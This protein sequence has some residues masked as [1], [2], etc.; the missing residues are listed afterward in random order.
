MDVLFCG[1]LEML[2]LKGKS[3]IPKEE[4]KARKKK[5]AQDL[6]MLQKYLK[7][8]KIPVIILFEGLEAAGKGSVI[9]FMA[10]SM[11]PRGFKVFP[12]L[13]PDEKEKSKPFLYRFWI[14]TPAKGFIHIFDRSWYMHVLE[15]RV[16]K[17]TG[18]K[19]CHI[20]FDEI[21]QFERTL[22]DNGT[23]VIKFWLH[24]SEKEQKKRLKKMEKS[25]EHRWRVGKKEWRQHKNY[26]K[27]IY[28][29][30]D[31]FAATNTSWSPWHLIST[32]DVDR[33]KLEVLEKIVLFMEKIVGKAFREKALDSFQKSMGI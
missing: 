12:V 29:A 24:I 28:S 3:S 33:G 31:M 25:R 2:D 9:E 7:G 11:D 21:N 20:A 5:I 22:K 18:K 4:Y 26:S 17:K 13:E 30:E 19:E 15:D 1:M 6:F 8:E 27:Y 23:Y 14:D 16:R 10:E 32:E